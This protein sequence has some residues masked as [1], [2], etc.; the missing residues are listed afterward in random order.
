VIE[1]EWWDELLSTDTRAALEAK[2]ASGRNAP[3]FAIRRLLTR[4]S[5]TPPSSQPK[6]IHGHEWC[7]R[8]EHGHE[9]ML[10]AMKDA[11]NDFKMAPATLAVPK[12]FYSRGEP[13]CQ[14]RYSNHQ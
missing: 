9:A 7:H 11:V 2:R 5:N 4:M 6:C 1:G 13:K 14:E 12:I 8:C 10:L 3:P